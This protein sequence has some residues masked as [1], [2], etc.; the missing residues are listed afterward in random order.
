[1]IITI[2]F[3]LLFIL[4]VICLIIYKVPP[5]SFTKF[6]DK[7]Y[8]KTNTYIKVEDIV[9][10]TSCLSIIIGGIALVICILV[11]IGRHVCVDLKIEQ[12]DIK[13]ETL[14]AKVELINSDYEDISKTDVL[15]EVEEWNKNVLKEK[16][17]FNNAF[18]SW[19]H[20]ERYVN[21]LQYIDLNKLKN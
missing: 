2:V 7:V 10:G 12:S 5:K 6:C 8:E 17:W 19:F 1:M 9:E 3:L 4:G 14:I 11:I 20:S 15:S 21:N 13:Y 16:Y 18:T